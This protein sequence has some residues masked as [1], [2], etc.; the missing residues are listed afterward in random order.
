[1][2][3]QM[4]RKHTN[5]SKSLS[6]LL[7]HGA[8]QN[9]IKVSPDG[10]VLLDD[11]LKM[12]QFSKNTLDEVQFV[13]DN[14]EKKRFDL[15]QDN[16]QYYIRANQGHSIEVASKIKQEELLTKLTEPLENVLHGT[17]YEKYKLIKTSGLK[18]M[19]RSHIHFAIT[20]D[21]VVGNKDQSGIRYNAE[22]LIFLDMKSA[23]SDGIE[24]Y[25]SQNKVVLSEGTKPDGLI[26]KKYFSRVVDRKTG[27]IV[28]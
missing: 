11:V 2:Q 23:M 18:K 13:V 25:V 24:F 15:K 4:D 21:F 27:N 1:M 7:R 22:V 9:G 5:L 26:D 16:S 10:Y 14:N 17:T 12:K 19:E 28:K 3:I 20:D 6:W 8:V